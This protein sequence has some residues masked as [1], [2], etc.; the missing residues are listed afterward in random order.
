MSSGAATD[1]LLGR[2]A[3]YLIRDRDAKFA[4]VFDAVFCAAGVEVVRISPRARRANAYAQFWVRTVRAECLDW[5]LVWNQRQLYRVLTE[6]LRRY[7]AVR[8]HRGLDLRAVASGSSPG[9]GRAG[10]R[11]VAG[12]TSRCARRS[13]SRVSSRRLSLVAMALAA[14]LNLVILAPDR[15]SLG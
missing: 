13:D 7:N 5:T 1:S 9:A 11:R 15:A 4:A 8:P 6:Y 12:G 3:R 10:P 2:F 14:V